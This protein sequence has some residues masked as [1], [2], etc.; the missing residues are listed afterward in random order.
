MRSPRSMFP[1][2]EMDSSEK[3]EENG[4]VFD[5][6]AGTFDIWMALLRSCINVH[7]SVSS[8]ICFSDNELMQLSN[9]MHRQASP[10]HSYLRP[11]ILLD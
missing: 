6:D 2:V 11:R 8:L 10:P 1:A 9:I 4:T 7:F 5:L 3:M